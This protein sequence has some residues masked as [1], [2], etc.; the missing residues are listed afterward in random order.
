M[1]CLGMLPLPLEIAQL[2][3]GPGGEAREELLARPPQAR[4]PCAL[5]SAVQWRMGEILP[6]DL[7]P[8]SF[9]LSYIGKLK[10]IM[11]G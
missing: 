3:T 7:L 4:Q 8:G 6:G 1:L 2:H 11:A 5:T 9:S 10:A